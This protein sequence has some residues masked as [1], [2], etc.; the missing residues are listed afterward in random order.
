MHIVLTGSLGHISRPLA[1]ELLQK[2]HAVTIISSDPQ[3]QTDIEALGAKAAIGSVED[4]IFL[5]KTFTG[6]DAA[7]CMTPPNFREADQVVYYERVAEAYAQAIRQSGIKRVVYLSSYGAHLSSGTGF[8]TGS[9]KAEN[10]LNAI[11]GISLTHIR[12]T[13]FYYNLLGFI[14]MI[15]TA[16]FIG[17][18]YGG[19]DKLAM[20]SPLDIASAIADEI[21]KQRSDVN[22]RYVTS[23]DKTCSEVAQVLGDAIGVPGLTWKILPREKALQS[24]LSNGLPENAANNLVE[25][26]MAIHTGALREDFDKRKPPFGKISLRDFAIEFAEAYNQYND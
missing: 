26:G 24:L 8:I 19:E 17:A 12:P 6:A 18:V 22:V 20:V 2:G 5:T 3:K 11:P 9:Y 23:D 25:L 4:D 7:Y 21:T 14:T 16:G 10:L 13:F 15:K 1:Q